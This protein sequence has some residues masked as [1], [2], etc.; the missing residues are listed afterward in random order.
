MCILG[1]GFAG[2]KMKTWEKIKLGVKRI[3]LR[4]L[5]TKSEAANKEKFRIMVSKKLTIDVHPISTSS[6][7]ID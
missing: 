5:I 1:G 7:K 3:G 2:N 4:L 6:K